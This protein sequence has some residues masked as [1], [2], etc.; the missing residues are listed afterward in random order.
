MSKYI[1]SSVLAAVFTF[2][3]TA[4]TAFAADEAN[5]NRQGVAIH[6]YDPVAYFDD[7]R[8]VRG[9]ESLSARHNGVAYRFSSQENLQKFTANPDKFAPAYGGWCSYGVRV[10]KKFDID[11]NAWKIEGG[12]LFLQLDLG[13]QK[14]WDKDRI[15]NIEIA[16]RLW[17]NIQST[18]AEALGK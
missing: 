16:D 18:S 9:S 5:L 12:R 14:V 3:L 1:L 13:T 8:P 6:G 7:A 2:G 11:P 4:A 17:P 15:K 10:G